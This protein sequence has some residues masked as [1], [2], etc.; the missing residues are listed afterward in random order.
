M[1]GL[2]TFFCGEDIGPFFTFVEFSLWECLFEGCGVFMG[3]MGE[4]ALESL[5]REC[6]TTIFPWS[7]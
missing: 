4:R 5:N 1:I 6:S 2:R 3:V 7:R